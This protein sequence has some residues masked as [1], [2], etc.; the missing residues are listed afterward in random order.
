VAPKNFKPKSQRIDFDNLSGEKQVFSI[1]GNPLRDE[2]ERMAEKYQIEEIAI[3]RLKD[4][5]YQ[6]LARPVLD[7]KGIDDLADSIKANGF[8]GALLARLKP[9]KDGELEY[10]LA[11]GHRRREAA[12]KAGIKV[13]PV[14][15]LELDDGQ[16]ARIMASE[17]FSRED[18]TPLGEANV[19]GFLNEQQNMSIAEIE[20]VVGRKRGWVATR[21]NLF[22]AP[23]DLK[24][25]V[26]EKP[27]TMSHLP[28][29]LKIK[30]E[31]KRKKYVKA[32]LE[33][34]LTRELLE[35]R[36]RHDE[37]PIKIVTEFTTVMQHED[38]EKDNNNSG[39]K[40]LQDILSGKE[41]SVIV[42]YAGRTMTLIPEATETKVTEGETLLAD[43]A[44]TTEFNQFLAR[45]SSETEVIGDFIRSKN[46]QATFEQ[47]KELKQIIIRL[48]R[49]IG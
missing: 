13:L 16:M 42:N 27:E 38:S 43:P 46:Y 44:L 21:L 10:E 49:Y 37:E 25:M 1:V 18:L 22:H 24:E 45:L 19:V 31:N 33:Q 2:L 30:E 48:G 20:K 40:A 4:N 26:A 32:V 3:N 34:G 5:P 12:N 47:K 23:S 15:V 6:N 29:L 36:I 7:P 14:K 41:S 8:Y 28:L 11:Y 17:N 35:E 39:L 9:N